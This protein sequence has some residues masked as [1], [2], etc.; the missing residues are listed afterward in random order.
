MSNNAAEIIR[1]LDR[2]VKSISKTKE[3][4]LQEVGQRGVGITKRNSPTISGRLKNSFGYTTN[5]SKVGNSDSVRKT[6]EKD[7]VIVGTNVAYARSVE[8]KS[9]T[10]SKGF[11]LRSF[12]QWKTISKVVA[13]QV[14]G[15]LKL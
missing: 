15:G 8:F 14:F 9:T 6:S 12:N 1:N 3:E 11:M 10:G 2:I 4:Y 13:K 5:K 7:T